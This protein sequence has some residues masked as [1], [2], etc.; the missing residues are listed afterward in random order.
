MNQDVRGVLFDIGGVLVA[1]DGVPLLAALLGVEADHETLHAL[2]MTSPAVVAHETGKIDAAGFAAG[3]VADLGLPTTADSFLRSFCRW[4]TGVLPGAL[5]IL[6]EIP[7]MYQLAA[8]S[9]TSAVHW[10][11]IVAMGLADRFSQTYLS[12]EIGHVK[13]AAEAFQIALN[14]MGLSPQEVLFLDDGLRNIEAA[15]TLGMR[16]HLARGP[17]E[18]RTVLV[19]YG[20]LSNSGA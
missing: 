5:E 16:A 17:E 12:Y 2:W 6:D 10:D 8:L 7:D 18:A 9:N 13:P 4:P 1:L 3:V 14:G 11:R 19:Q 15:K 20:V